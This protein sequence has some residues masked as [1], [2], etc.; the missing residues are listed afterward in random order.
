MKRLWQKFQDWRKVNVYAKR[1]LTIGEIFYR[2]AVWQRCLLMILCALTAYKFL[3]PVFA[4]NVGP[5]WAKLW[6][7]DGS[8]NPT[9]WSI[10]ENQSAGVITLAVGALLVGL[11]QIN[12]VQKALIIAA[13][14]GA[15]WM[16]LSTGTATQ[17]LSH[18][19][20][21]NAARKHNERIAWLDKEIEN[22]T[23]VWQDI[24]AQ[25]H[26]VATQATV[27]VIEK[28][29]KT[30]E[31]R[32][33]DECHA[34][35]FGMT[36]GPR[37]AELEKQHA[38]KLD[39][40]TKA[41]ADKDL[42]DRA[43]SIELATQVLKNERK[44]LGSEAEHPD[45]P[46]VWTKFLSSL[47]VFSA[48]TAKTLTE[49]KPV[50][51][52]IAAE[53]FGCGMTAPCIIGC[54]WLFGMFTCHTGE[55][56]ERVK[57]VAQAAAAEKAKAALESVKPSGIVL[58]DAPKAPAN[59]LFEE[60]EPDT[61]S[62]ESILEIEGA[63][64]PAFVENPETVA[65]AA[66]AAF[67]KADPHKKQERKAR[68]K[69]AASRDS[70]KLW[71]KERAFECEGRRTRSTDATSDYRRWCKE[72]NLTPVSPQTFGHVMRKE[73]GILKSETDGRVTYLNMGLRPAA[74]RVVSG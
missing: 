62:L 33:Y 38:A 46:S 59:N 52:T 47:G 18:D 9:E 64:P 29:A 69:K 8:F 60:M 58:T 23:K 49:F 70:V 66:A 35:T 10:V 39:E 72:R 34:G 25:P 6:N 42:T 22:N 4:M 24:Q 11:R 27:D 7:P 1:G 13:M 71:H 56:E 55:A 26:K 65:E 19:D 45:E 74:L 48:E 53:L 40:L 14:C 20:R 63:E 61:P 43:N 67:I 68:T 17:T 41:Q 54:F 73:L 44:E 15:V 57:E 36:R 5:H 37:C 21:N 16:N 31:K 32:A 28:A 2:L 50:T 51:D 12:Y 30:L 3:A